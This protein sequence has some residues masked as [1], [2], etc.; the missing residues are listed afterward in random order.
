MK[1]APIRALT[2][3][4]ILSTKNSVPVVEM[5]AAPIRALTLFYC[6]SKH[7]LLLGRNEGRPY[8]GIDTISRIISSIC[9]SRP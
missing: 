1:A 6:I 4:I 9:F 7:L 2:Q 5:K 3:S 8:Q